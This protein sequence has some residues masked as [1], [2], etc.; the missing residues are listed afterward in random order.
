MSLFFI[1]GVLSGNASPIDD[2]AAGI[3]IPLIIVCM[4]CMHDACVIGHYL[5]SVVSDTL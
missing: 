1:I 5:L 3:Y 4:Q 2:L